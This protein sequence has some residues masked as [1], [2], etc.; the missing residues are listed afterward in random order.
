MEEIQSIIETKLL[1]E[2]CEINKILPLIMR[3]FMDIIEQI[4][5]DVIYFRKKINLE[6]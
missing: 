5:A 4:E 1:D 2:K 3:N 6:I